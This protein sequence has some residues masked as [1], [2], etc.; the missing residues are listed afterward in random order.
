MDDTFKQ[1]QQFAPILV[2]AVS[3][4]GYYY[5]M[6]HVAPSKEEFDQMTGAKIAAVVAIAVFIVQSNVSEVIA[7]NEV[8]TTPFYEKP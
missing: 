4:A 8:M 5:Y 2:G 6:Q 7:K 3:F 1:Y